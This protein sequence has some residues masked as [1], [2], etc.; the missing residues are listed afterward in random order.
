MNIFFDTEFT[1]LHQHTTLISFGAIDESGEHVFYH[2]L[3][4]YDKDQVDAWIQ[5]NVINKLRPHQKPVPL[6]KL[7]FD[8]EDWLQDFNEEIIMWGD[9]LAYDWMLFCQL[10]GGALNVPKYIHYIPRDIC[11]LFETHG[12]DPDISRI[13]FAGHI[14]SRSSL[15]HNALGDAMLV[16][17]CYRK[18][19]GEKDILDLRER[20]LTS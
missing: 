18:I 16:R 5:E 13:E 17:D 2:E 14:E 9:C 7:K 15:R 8:L 11:T 19:Q 4:D 12:I 10:W 20:W 1:G 3:N 6:E